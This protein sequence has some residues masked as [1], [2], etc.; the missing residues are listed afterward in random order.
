MLG[1]C[2]RATMEPAVNQ[3]SFDNAPSVM[4]L[5]AITE[6]DHMDSIVPVS[7]RIVLHRA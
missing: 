4:D 3:Q 5:G 7:T 1:T 6:G 2:V